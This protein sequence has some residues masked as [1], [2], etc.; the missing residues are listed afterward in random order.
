VA[1]PAE[2]RETWGGGMRSDL[3]EVLDVR[4]GRYVLDVRLWGKGT[5][6]GVETDQTLRLPLYLPSGRK[7]HPRSTL[8]GRRSR[9]D[10]GGGIRPAKGLIQRRRYSGGWR[11]AL[12]VLGVFDNFDRFFRAADTTLTEPSTQDVAGSTPVGTI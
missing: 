1:L 4:Y 8:P 3:L 6:S 9:G 12:P 5:R 7:G 10:C 11:E 2:L